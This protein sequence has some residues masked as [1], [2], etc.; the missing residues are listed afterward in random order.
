MCFLTVLN[1]LVVNRCH[2]D[3]IVASTRTS[4]CHYEVHNKRYIRVESI[5]EIRHN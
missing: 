2:I 5:L 3:E 1:K 4:T